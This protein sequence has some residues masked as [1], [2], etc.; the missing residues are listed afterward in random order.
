VTKGIE[1]I[2]QMKLNLKEEGTG[3]LF[4]PNPLW[5]PFIPPESLDCQRIQFKN[6]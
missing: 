4:H 5:T 3:V 6:H 1:I 2:A